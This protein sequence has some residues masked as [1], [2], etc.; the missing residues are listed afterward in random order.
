[1]PV[2][3]ADA[4]LLSGL[5]LSPSGGLP[6]GV[7]PINWGGT[8]SSTTTGVQIQWQWGAAVYTHFDT[9][10]AIGVKPVHGAADNYPGGD[11][12]GVPE[13]E[14]S[15]VIG[16]AR[17]GGGSNWTGSWSGTGSCNG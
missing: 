17:G 4:D 10:N 11:H 16:G 14:R 15:Y 13:N 1:M 5:R 6:G 9:Y 3:G 12:A 7:N 2:S 8:F